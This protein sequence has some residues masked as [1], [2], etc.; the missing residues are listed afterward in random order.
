MSCLTSL[1]GFVCTKE[2]LCN[3]SD[4]GLVSIGL[5]ALTVVSALGQ[6]TDTAQVRATVTDGSGALVPNAKVMMTNEG[7][8]VAGTLT[9]DQAGLCIFNA[10]QPASYTIKAWT[11]GFK[12]SVREHVVLRVGQQIDLVFSLEIGSAAQTLVVEGE[13]PQINT[14][15]GAL[16]TEVTN[17][18]I[19]DMPLLDRNLASLS[20]LAPGVTEVTGSSINTLGGTNFVSN[21][22]RYA[23]AEFR[24]DGGLASAP[25]G[26][27]GDAT[28]VAYLPSVELIQEFKAAKQQ[29]LRRVRQQ[30]WDRGQY[31]YQVRD[32]SVS[33]QRLVSPHPRI[34]NDFFQLSGPA[35][36]AIT[37]TTST[38]PPWAV[39]S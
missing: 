6:G 24:L 10:V 5:A 20:Y 31:R 23:T 13:A 19:I 27:E 28:N 38:V 29:L 12:T 18:Y 36:R 9:T 4:C 17:R 14:V 34:A 2:V 8:G 37:R 39:P 35:R 3:S 32:Q 26:G 22:Q 1:T 7:T 21:G 15:S 16:G 30:R 33:R 11:D 25:E